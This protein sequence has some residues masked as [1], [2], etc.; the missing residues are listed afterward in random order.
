MQIITSH[1]NIIDP[2]QVCGSPRN[3]SNKEDLST[4]ILRATFDNSLRNMVEES[5]YTSPWVVGIYMTR[6]K[7]HDFKCSGTIISSK[8]IVSGNINNFCNQCNYY[9]LY[10]TQ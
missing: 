5:V 6:S 1:C 10:T 3:D 7:H 2:D 8:I 4:F 9:F